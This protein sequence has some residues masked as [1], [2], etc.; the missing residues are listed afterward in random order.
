MQVTSLACFVLILALDVKGEIMQ[1]DFVVLQSRKVTNIQS[2]VFSRSRLFCAKSCLN[3]GNCT[4]ASYNSSNNE[5][6]FSTDGLIDIINVNDNNMATI[7]MKGINLK[8]LTFL[9]IKQYVCNA[10][11]YNQMGR[12][13]FNASITD[14]VYTCYYK[15]II[16]GR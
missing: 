7:L 2:T 6:L 15:T 12:Q 16:N 13:P 11:P 4:S 3:A 1:K 9:L 8:F 10:T 14:I 5:C